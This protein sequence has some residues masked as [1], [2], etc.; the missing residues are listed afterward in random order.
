MTR[1]FSLFEEAWFIS[2][3]QDSNI[4]WNRKALQQP[5]TMPPSG[6]KKLKAFPLRLET[7]QGYPLSPL[8]FNMVLEVLDTVIREEK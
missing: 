8:L 6:T 4:E 3:A 7:R 2:E 1:G 5:F